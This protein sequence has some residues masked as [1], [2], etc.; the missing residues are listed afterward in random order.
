MTIAYAICSENDIL[1]RKSKVFSLLRIGEDGKPQ[2]WTIFVVRWNKRVFGY[3][4][5]CPHDG[6][7]LDWEENQ[8]LDDTGRR[9]VCGKHGSVFELATGKCI[10]GPCLGQGLESVSVSV[11]DGDICVTGVTLAED[12]EA[13]GREGLE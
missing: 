7:H 10:D 5:R 9:I 1:H 3:V 12:E 11:I 4:N 6:V 2:P 8:F 13:L